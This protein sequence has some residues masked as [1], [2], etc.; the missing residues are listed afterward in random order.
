LSW[1]FSK[2]IYVE[3][4]ICTG[5]A[6]AYVAVGSAGVGGRDSKGDYGTFFRFFNALPDGPCEGFSIWN[7]MIRGTEQQKVLWICN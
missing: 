5:F 2:A 6:L 4:A 7:V 1:L 3:Y